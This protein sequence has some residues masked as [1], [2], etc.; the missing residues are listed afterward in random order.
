MKSRR[1][2]CAPPPSAQDAVYDSRHEMRLKLAANGFFEARTNQSI[3]ERQ[4]GDVLGVGGEPFVPLRLRNPL[5]EDYAVMR[6]SLLPGLLA[7]AQN[8]IRF[9]VEALR[10]FEV[11]T[12]YGEA[13]DARTGALEITALGVLLSG[14]HVP[15]SWRKKR[16][17]RS[18]SSI[19]GVPS[20]C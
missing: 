15:S 2:P 10:L 19:C 6:P 16:R 13:R 11:G 8:N 4:L 18:S 14:P 9:G 1:E 20:T 12:I 3:P 5:S 7:A 17:M